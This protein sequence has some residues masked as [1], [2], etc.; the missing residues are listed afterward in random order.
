ML[1][2]K[3]Y[4]VSRDSKANIVDTIA[5]GMAGV[6]RGSPMVSIDVT[7]AVP[8]AGFEF[9]AGIFVQNLVPANVYVQGP[10]GTTLQGV[11]FITKDDL[12]QSVNAEA[13]Y[14]FSCVGPLQQ[15]IS[16]NGA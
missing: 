6:S 15:W 8:A 7:S 10:G 11:V 4:K 9:D 5:L 13:A 16:A 1:Q 3:S 14:S 12:S 2:A